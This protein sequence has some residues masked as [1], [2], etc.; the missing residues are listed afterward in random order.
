MR[1]A[2][3]TGVPMAVAATL[4]ACAAVAGTGLG[5]WWA[6][7][8]DGVAGSSKGARPA[9]ATPAQSPQPVVGAGTDRV[10]A[11]PDRRR[12]RAVD[13]SAHAAGGPGTTSRATVRRVE[14]SGH[15]RKTGKQHATKHAKHA[16]HATKGSKS[17]AE[18]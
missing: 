9:V 12:Q 8:G 6:G 16:K 18:R 10:P 14:P 7:N 3:A 11:R 13:A 5:A 17:N 1:P 4:L 2:S 15:A